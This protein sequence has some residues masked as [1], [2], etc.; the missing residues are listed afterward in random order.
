MSKYIPNRIPKDIPNKMPKNIS[1][2]I[3]KNISNKMPKHLSIIKYIIIIIKIIQNN[4][5]LIISYVFPLYIKK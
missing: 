1:N 5:F 2:K 3:L 4:I